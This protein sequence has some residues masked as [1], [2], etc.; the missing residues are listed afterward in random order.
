MDPLTGLSVASNIVQFIDFSLRV[1]SKGCKIYRSIDGTLAENLDL[2]IVT[3]DLIVLQTK[4]QRCYP[5]PYQTSLSMDD[6]EAFKKL[7]EA[8]ARLAAKLLE[9]LNMAKAQGRFRKWKSLR[10]AVKSVWSKGDVEETASRLQIFRTELQLHLLVT[11][12]YVEVGLRPYKT[13]RSL[14]NVV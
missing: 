2:E 10:Q 7:S 1:V 5:V 11:L 8:C 12:R 9:K 3:N 6:A 13:I 14:L 4:L